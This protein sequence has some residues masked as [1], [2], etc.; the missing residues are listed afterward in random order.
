M[1]NFKN[2]LLIGL[3]G[4]SLIFTSCDDDTPEEEN[5][6]EV[7][8]NVTLIFTNTTNATDIVTANAVDPDGV[9]SQELQVLGGITLTSGATYRLT[10]E[11][12]NAL[13]PADIE[14]IGEEIEEED[15]EHQFFYAF[16]DGAFTSPMGDGNIDAASDP[17]NYE[18]EDSDAQDGSGNP[19]GLETTWTTGSAL[20]S[21]TFRVRLQHQPDVKTSTSGSTDGDTDFDLT[22]DLTIE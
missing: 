12:L 11:I 15:D 17:I 20:A 6:V 3:L 21:G 9:G 4:F 14:D 1:K 5:V 13:D 22:F 7:F 8:T 19:V 18:D 2:Y 16:T 10:Y